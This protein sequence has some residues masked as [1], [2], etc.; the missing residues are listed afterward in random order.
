MQ[1]PEVVEG[2]FFAHH[3]HQRGKH[4][5]RR[6]RRVGIGDL[7][8]AL[9][10]WLDQVLPAARSAQPLL[11]EQFLVVA[12]AQGARIDAYS[13]VFGGRGLTVRPIKQ[14]VAGLRHIGL[15]QAFFSGLQ[16]R[17]TGAAPPDVAFG[18]GGL[19]LDLGVGF[20]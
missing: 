17:V 15:G 12:I 19:G 1:R 9:E 2:L 7:H 8:L 11:F 16:V 4:G 13:A 18:I 6:A 10:F 14:L 3:L 5:V 20:A